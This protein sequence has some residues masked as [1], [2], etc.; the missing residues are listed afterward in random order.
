MLNRVLG[1]FGYSLAARGGNYIP[2][3]QTIAAARRARLSVSDYVERMWSIEGQTDFVVA[4]MQRTGALGST[5]CE[6]GPG[7]GRYTERILRLVE[8]E[9]YEVYETAPDWARYLEATYPVTR[10]PAD[11]ETLAHT[12]ADS[13]ALV[14][15]HGVFVYTPPMVAFSYFSE[16]MRVSRRW[17]VFDCIPGSLGGIDAR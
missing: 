7:T 15:A 13:C 1:P 3:K 17:I 8:C 11:G 2:A 12:P 10:R 14:H 9:W 5:V 4:E 6:I 16:M